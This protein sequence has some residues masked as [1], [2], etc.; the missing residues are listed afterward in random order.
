[1]RQVCGLI[2]I[3][4]TRHF[5]V[6]LA[7]MLAGLQLAT[8]DAMDTEEGALALLGELDETLQESLTFLVD[9]ICE[10]LTSSG[11]DADTV[12]EVVAQ[13]ITPA[14]S[15]EHAMLFAYSLIEYWRDNT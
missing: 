2:K 10:H 6:C 8:L 11:I 12:A 3:Q 4:Y 15:E 13:A 9:L 1:M 5:F 14:P 7:G